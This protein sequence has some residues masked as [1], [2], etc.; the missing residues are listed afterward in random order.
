LKKL[1]PMICIFIK[2]CINDPLYGRE[3]GLRGMQQRRVIERHDC[4]FLLT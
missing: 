2:I 1:Y 4:I 3:R